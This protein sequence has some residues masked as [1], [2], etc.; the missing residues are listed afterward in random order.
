MFSPDI[1]FP[2]NRGGRADVWRRIKAFRQFGHEV[3]LINYQEQ[4]GPSSPTTDALKSVDSVVN[5]RYSFFMKRGFLIMAKRLALSWFVP[6]HAAARMPSFGEKLSL[7][8]LLDQFKP[9]YLWLDGPWFSVLCNETSDRY[10][11]PI[12]YRSHNIEH[13]YLPGQAKVAVRLR[14][15]VAWSLACVGLRRFEYDAIKRALAVFDIS[16]DDMSYWKSRG[17]RHIHWL[18]PFPELAFRD[19]PNNTF[20]SDIVFIGNLGTPNNVRGVEWFVTEVLPRVRALFPRIVCRVVGSNPT[21]FILKLLEMEVDVELCANVPDT[22]PYLFGAKVLVN[23]VMSGSGVQVKMLDM[24]M[25]D[26]PIV[27]SSQGTRG[28]PAE[29][30]SLFRIADD[31]DAF[32]RAVIEE[33]NVPSVDLSVRGAARNIFSVAA[34]EQVL[35]VAASAKVAISHA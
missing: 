22:T 3:F 29:F 21:P 26:A 31:A 23:P 32:A 2:P 4:D 18:P 34:I 30:K 24:L 19:R 13:V 6:W 27:T 10:A 7:F 25:T 12:L 14:D 8:S 28:L 16:V 17:M 33:L 15:R 9:D 11:A 20:S 5:Q 1:P 35:E